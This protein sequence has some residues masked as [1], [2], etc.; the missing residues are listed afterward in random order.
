MLVRI[1]PVVLGHASSRKPD[2]GSL[3]GWGKGVVS[4]RSTSP[5]RPTEG[6]RGTL[7][8]PQHVQLRL[9][10]SWRPS[11]LQHC[12]RA[13]DSLTGLL[14]KRNWISTTRARSSSIASA[15]HMMCT[16]GARA[17]GVTPLPSR[18]TDGAP[19]LNSMLNGSALSRICWL[20]PSGNYVVRSWVAGA[21]PVSVMATS[22]RRS[23]M[24]RQFV[25][26]EYISPTC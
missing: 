23:Q 3:R 8:C 17:S 1:Q 26:W 9:V 11:S 2:I 13:F 5:F 22:S 6:S 21:S 20:P 15:S 12:R 18:S 7:W 4:D 25:F 10:W 16:S 24:N 14:C 19:H